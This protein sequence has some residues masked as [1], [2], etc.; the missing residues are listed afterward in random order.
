MKY[1]ILYLVI[2]NVVTLY[3]YGIDKRRAQRKKW[4]IPEAVLLLFAALGGSIGAWIAM[5]AFHHKTQHKKFTIG[6]PLIFILQVAAT[7]FFYTK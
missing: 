7:I 5:K 6:V 2:I 4:R 3:L 1:L